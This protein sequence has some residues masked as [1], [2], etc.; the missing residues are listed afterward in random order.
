MAGPGGAGEARTGLIDMTIILSLDLHSGTWV[1]DIVNGLHDITFTL[2][3][4]QDAANLA[5]HFSVVLETPVSVTGV[6]T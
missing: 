5:G 4:A 3:S 2:P 6:A 1:V